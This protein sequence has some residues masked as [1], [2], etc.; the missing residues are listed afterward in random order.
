M[1]EVEVGV[2]EEAILGDGV[3]VVAEAAE[4]EEAAEVV[5]GDGVAEEEGVVGGSGVVEAKAAEEEERGIIMCTGG[6]GGSVKITISWESM[7]NACV[8]GGVRA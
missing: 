3:V 4:E 8:K 6:Q 7:Q 2:E 1:A 5:G